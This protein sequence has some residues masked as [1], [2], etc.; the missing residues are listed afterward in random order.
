M[1]DVVKRR[2]NKRRTAA[3]VGTVLAILCHFLP[4][5]YHSACQTVLKIAGLSCSTGVQP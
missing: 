2:L 4:Y 5:E 3:L 1:A